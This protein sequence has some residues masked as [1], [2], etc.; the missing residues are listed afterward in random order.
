MF[1]TWCLVMSLRKN[2]RNLHRFFPSSFKKKYVPTVACAVV[3]LGP[4]GFVFNACP[5]CDATCPL[6]SCSNQNDD[7]AV[8]LTV[9]VRLLVKDLFVYKF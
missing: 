4:A 1:P 3:F 2:T 8:A 9:F 6:S 5:G 7:H